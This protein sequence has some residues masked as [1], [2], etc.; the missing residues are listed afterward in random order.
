[1]NKEVWSWEKS[2]LKTNHTAG[3]PS[4]AT[5]GM[6]QHKVDEFMCWQAGL[7]YHAFVAQMESG[8]KVLLKKVDNTGHWKMHVNWVFLTVDIWFERELLLIPTDIQKNLYVKLVLWQPIKGKGIFKGR[9]R[10]TYA[11]SLLQGSGKA[12]VGEL[13]TCLRHWSTQEGGQTN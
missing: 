1:M 9:K 10:L 12:T 5:T 13:R 6:N 2:V 4:Y 3:N 11:D 8:H 7:T